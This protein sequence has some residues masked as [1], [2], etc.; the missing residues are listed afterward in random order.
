[1]TDVH[2][3]IGQFNDKYYDS[4]AVFDAIEQ[5]ATK[6]GIDCVQYSSTSS[7]RYDVE[8]S[9]VEEEIAFAQNYKSSVI[10]TQ[11]YLWFTPRYA[12]QGI[13][14]KSALQT[15]DYCGI[16]LHPIAHDWDFADSSHKKSL[17]EI[18]CCCGETH[19][20]ILIH[21]GIGKVQSPSR[22]ECFI[23]NYPA[24]NVILAHSKP[25]YA[26]TKMM[27]KYPNVKCDIA[28]LT[29]KEIRHLLLCTKR[30]K[31]DQARVLFG[32]DFPITHYYNEENIS[33]AQQY[34]KDCTNG[35]TL[36]LHY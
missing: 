26:T 14:V 9:R 30:H 8:L 4:H 22:F 3:H 12:R 34:K 5:T 20:P 32:S 6:F 33:L 16:K 35:L 24:A 29:T 23:K 2:V 15:F 13:S 10:K 17:E 11:P 36:Q 25:C 7:C 1:M 19:K 28:F 27:S 21:C 18:F 31:I